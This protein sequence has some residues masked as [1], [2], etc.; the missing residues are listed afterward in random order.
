MALSAL[1]GLITF[2]CTTFF[3]PFARPELVFSLVDFLLFF[4]FCFLFLNFGVEF[5]GGLLVFLFAVDP[6]LILI[7]SVNSN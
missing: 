4:V 2:R 5:C 7:F 1:G 6:L 3:F